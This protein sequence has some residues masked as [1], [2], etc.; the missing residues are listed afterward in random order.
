MS[1]K[2]IAIQTIPDRIYHTGSSDHFL[3]D[4]VDGEYFLFEYRSINNAD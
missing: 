2:T 1:I 4:P 3:L